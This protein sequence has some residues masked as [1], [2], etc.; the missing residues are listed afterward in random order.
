MNIEESIRKVLNEW[1]AK[2]D[3]EKQAGVPYKVVENLI[4]KTMSKKYDWWK[5]LEIEELNFAETIDTVT[6]YGIINID[7]DWG[8]N[9]YR[10]YNYSRSFPGNDG[11]EDPY[12]Y[13]IVHLGDIIGNEMSNQL[14]KDLKPII[15][16]VTKYRSTKKIR[17]GVLKIKFV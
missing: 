6:I 11:W 16:G 14:S 7:E 12:E 2:I 15:T 9:Q 5:G 1:Y 17:I 4:N 3:K 8:G 10:E 13:E